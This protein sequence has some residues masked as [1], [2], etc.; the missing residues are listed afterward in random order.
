M[1][2]QLAWRRALGACGLLGGL[3]GLALGRWEKG[4]LEKM[5]EKLAGDLEHVFSIYIYIYT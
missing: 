2:I 5:V 3:G 1:D 4:A